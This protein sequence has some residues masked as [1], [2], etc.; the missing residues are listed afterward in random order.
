MPCQYFSVSDFSILYVQVVISAGFCVTQ[1]ENRK[2]FDFFSDDEWF[3]W[4]I[5]T[6]IDGRSNSVTT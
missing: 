2:G 3:V 1:Q 4:V 6:D 5:F